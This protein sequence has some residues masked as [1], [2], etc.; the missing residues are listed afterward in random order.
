MKPPQEVAELLEGA[1]ATGA[2]APVAKVRE[3]RMLLF[4]HVADVRDSRNAVG[5]DGEV[6]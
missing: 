6:D 3:D 2:P 4:A 5:R 1:A